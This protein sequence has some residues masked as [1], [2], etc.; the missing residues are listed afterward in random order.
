MV[1]HYKVVF[2]G[3]TSVGKSSIVMRFV[4]DEFLEA[5]EPTIGAAFLSKTI[6]LDD[7]NVKMEI[8][9]TAG[10]ER[11]RSLAPMYYRGAKA[12]FVVYD[13]TNKDSFIKA[14][15]LINEVIRNGDPDV[16]IVLFGN[17]IDMQQNRE[18][19]REEGISYAEEHGFIFSEISAKTSE[20]IQDAI[21]KVSLKLLER[22]PTKPRQD[23]P[24]TKSNNGS[25]H[26]HNNNKCC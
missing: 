16:I 25:C 8:W 9:D 11:Y 4:R 15:D 10:Q 18:V 1:D 23:D 2:L 26:H 12:A 3:E 22:K 21:V 6:K 13:I 24:F 20:N 17:K 19:E 7:G 5:H 14:K